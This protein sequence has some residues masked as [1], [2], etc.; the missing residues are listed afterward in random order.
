MEPRA[1]IGRNRGQGHFNSKECKEDA[2]TIKKMGKANDLEVRSLMF[3]YGD[4]RNPLDETV[5]VL[6]EMVTE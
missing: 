3:A 4:V 5:K 6:D 1:R 2:D